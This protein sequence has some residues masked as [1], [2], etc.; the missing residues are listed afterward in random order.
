[1]RY[2]RWSREC[3][4][5]DVRNLIQVEYSANVPTP[6]RNAMIAVLTSHKHMSTCCY[7][8]IFCFMDA[9]WN[10]VLFGLLTKYF[11]P[12]F[13]Y[14][15]IS[16][17]GC[18]LKTIWFG[19]SSKYFLSTCCY[20]NIFCFMDALWNT[21][22]FGLLTKYFLPSFCYPNI[23]VFGCSLKTIWFGLSSK[24]FLSTCCYPNIF[25]FMDALWNAV[26]KRLVW[27]VIQIFFAISL[28]SKY[29]YFMDA[30]WNFFGLVCIQIISM[31][32]LLS[33]YFLFFGRASKYS[34]KTAW[35]GLLSKYF[36]PSFS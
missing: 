22:L 27:F 3:R 29:V 36:L 11:L 34:L 18:S 9:L 35:F 2:L 33:K 19:L 15:N 16:V 20:P 10:T 7:P 14:P 17:F 4:T 24:Y 8:N 12:S 32:L 21:V 26:W 28:L 23:S 6:A 25:C 5:F 30:A 31:N 13:C 1:M